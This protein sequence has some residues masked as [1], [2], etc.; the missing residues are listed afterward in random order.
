MNRQKKL[1]LVSIVIPVYNMEKYLEAT[2]QSVFASTYS[3]YEIIL[4]DDSSEDNSYTICKQY[5]NE[6]ENV[7]CFSQPNGGPSAARN[8][9]IRRAK[10][11]YILPV[12]ADDLIASDYI[13]LAVNTIE[14]DP[15]IKVVYSQGWFI[16][17]R[18]GVWKRPAF[19]LQLLARKNMIDICALYRKIDWERVGGYNEEIKSRED[20]M[21]WIA[22]LKDGGKVI[23]LQNTGIYYRI[24]KNSKRITDRENKNKV[25]R[26][27]NEQHPE[28]FRKH[29]K[30]P[31]RNSR[32]WSKIINTFV[33][34][35]H[36]Q[37]T[38]IHTDYKE[39]EN[40][41]YSIPTLFRKGNGERIYK[42]RNELRLFKEGKYDLVVKSYKRPHLI[43][44][45]VYGF[46]RSSKAERSYR[47][48]L[49]L[50]KNEIKTPQPIAF[51]TRRRWLL[52]NDSYSVSL[53]SELPYIYNDLK[54]RH[55][56]R[57][58]EIVEQIA[59]TAA[60]M[61]EKGFLHKDFSGGNIL[62]DDDK[63]DINVELVDLNRICFKKVGKD[64]GCKNLERLSSTNEITSLIGKTYAIERGYDPDS[65]VK[66]M[67][68]YIKAEE[69]SRKISY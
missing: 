51:L 55:F 24:R 31:L 65:F 52:F 56:E 6:N 42:G 23:Q 64:D 57:Q 5:E 40:F 19:S 13:E 43:N 63:K 17:D 4:I 45:I 21:F 3:N 25:I 58:D 53:K 28:F 29:L 1:P 49:I 68:I 46:L 11:K 35:L 10:G 22:I 14:S 54:K 20:W 61:H 33:N 69:E 26:Y 18:T 38:V 16:G 9:A 32:S 12:D 41:V 15:D 44:Q 60:Y 62:F 30:G 2:L 67:N 48:G 34:I 47:Y 37:K 59:R 50:L 27:L 8:N 7:F 36:P 39:L 66:R